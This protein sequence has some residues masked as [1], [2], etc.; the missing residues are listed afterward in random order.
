MADEQLLPLEFPNF[1]LDLTAGYGA[2]RPGTTPVGTN[3][4]VY[5][6]G[7][8]RAR[9][10]SRPGITRYVLPQLPTA[11]KIQCLDYVVDP[12]ATALLANDLLDPGTTTVNDPS[13]NPPGS[14]PGDPTDQ[15]VRNRGNVWPQG[16]SGLQ[17]NRHI[18]I[19]KKTPNT[20]TF[21]AFDT[22]T[23][24]HGS[25]TGSPALASV[26]VGDLLILAVGTDGTLGSSVTDSLGN[27]YTLAKSAS[28]T[29]N[30]LRVWYAKSI[31]SGSVT[32]TI[33]A[34][35]NWGACY[36]DY[37]PSNPSGVAL[38]SSASAVLPPATGGASVTY[39]LANGPSVTASSTK[40]LVI[41]FYFIGS[42]NSIVSSTDI[43]Q[44]G[45][46]YSLLG[47][48]SGTSSATAQNNIDVHLTDAFASVL[49]IDSNVETDSDNPLSGAVND[50]L[51]FSAAGTDDGMGHSYVVG[52]LTVTSIAV[53]FK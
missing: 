13:T 26:S 6:P 36:L 7:T 10:G 52:N 49:L 43:G 1:G 17:P 2:Q 29:N 45:L 33:T 32:A 46:T 41:G 38:D 21:T 11:T 40:D 14:N 20:Y 42:S 53:A 9:G 31:G 3:V 16:G 19:K 48:G 50:S 4:R 37:T 27:T 18:Q 25:P 39:P 28:A 24:F 5:E 47:G 35:G 51:A 30:T 44:S 34:T 22:E 12:D 23:I 15:R 8:E